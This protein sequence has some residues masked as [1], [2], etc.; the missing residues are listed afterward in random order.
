VSFMEN[1]PAFHG[2]AAN[3]EQL[4]AALKELEI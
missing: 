4:V 3:A 2:K 1:N